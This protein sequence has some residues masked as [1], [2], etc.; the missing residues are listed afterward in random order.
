MLLLSVNVHFPLQANSSRIVTKIRWVVES[1]NSRVKQ[2]KYHANIVPNTQ[3]PH[4]GDYIR[5]ICAICNKYK[6]LLNVGNAE[7]DRTLA[8]KM[9]VF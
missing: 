8:A 6:R 9:K 7:D 4:I 3:I 5:M 1:V 2:W